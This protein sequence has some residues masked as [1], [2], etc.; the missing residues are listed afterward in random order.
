[1]KFKLHLKP[2]FNKNRKKNQ[3]KSQYLYMIIAAA[4]CLLIVLSSLYPSTAKPFKYIATAIVVPVQNGMNEIGQWFS[5]KS[6]SLKKLSQVV[7][8]NENLQAQ[9][10]ELTLENSRLIQEQGELARLRE[11]YS[12]DSGYSSYDKIAAKVI[13]KDSGNWF[14]T[15]IIDKGSSDG[16]AVDMNVIAGKGLVGI[17]IDVT[18]NSATVRSIIDDF[19]NVSAKFGTTSDLC[20]VKGSLQMMQSG[21]IELININKNAAVTDGDMILTSNVSDKYLP[22]ILIGYSGGIKDDANN[23]TKSGYITPVVNF[24]SLEE[25]LVIKQLKETGE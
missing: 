7:K 14:S 9:V 25:V 15:F 5:E 4:C 10:D 6:D 1:M 18:P 12:L 22:D 24:S 13:A 11:L 16:I 8:E 23:L 21:I 19:S 3:L 2:I 20:I 17:V